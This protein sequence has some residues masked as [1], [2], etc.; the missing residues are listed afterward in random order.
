MS[1]KDYAKMYSGRNRGQSGSRIPYLL[2]GLLLLIL[3]A[4]AAYYFRHASGLPKDHPAVQPEQQTAASSASVEE[5]A[6]PVA[7]DF[8]NTLPAHEGPLPSASEK[9]AVAVAPAPRSQATVQPASVQAAKEPTTK[10]PSAHYV[11]QLG[12]FADRKAAARTRLNF[13]LSGVDSVI[14]RETAEGGKILFRIQQG[15]Y[16]SEKAALAASTKFHRRGVEAIVRRV[17]DIDPNV[18]T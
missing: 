15:S 18:P 13:L 7:F 10:A 5:T 14:V 11:L 9:V 12:V 8:Y 1:S 3:A 2:G 16:L 17:V 6:P 4:G